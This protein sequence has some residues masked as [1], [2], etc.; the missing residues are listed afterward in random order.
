MKLKRGL[1]L[2]SLVGIVTT[3]L[4]VYILG[5]IDSES[6]QNW[7]DRAGIFAPILYVVIYAIATFLLLP[8]SA[9]NL[10][11]GAIFGLWMGTLWT[12]LAAIIAAIIAFIFTRT[13]GRK[14]VEKRLAGRWKAMDAEIRRGGRFYMFAIRLLPL[15]PYGL[16]N[17]TAGLTSVT[18]KDY[19]LGTMLGTVPGVFPFVMLGSTG[20][21]AVTTGDILPLLGALSLTGLLVGGATWYRHRRR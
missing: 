7:L 11:G 9:L 19:L 14:A 18:F 13:V 16:V 17:F 4:T 15:F 12:S 21:T 8:S 20:L 5:G 2:L 6:L 3:G 10:T 1:L